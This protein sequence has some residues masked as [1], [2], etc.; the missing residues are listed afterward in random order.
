VV[1]EGRKKRI[2]EVVN[3]EGNVRSSGIL[4][5]DRSGPAGRGVV[6]VYEGRAKKINSGEKAW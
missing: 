2:R 3:S 1:K 4:A 5:L 6:E